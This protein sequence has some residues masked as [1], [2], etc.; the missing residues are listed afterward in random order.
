ME[1]CNELANQYV[2]ECET[3]AYSKQEQPLVKVTLCSYKNQAE[4]TEYIHSRFF[5]F[6]GG[7]GRGEKNPIYAFLSRKPRIHL[8]Y[9]F[10]CM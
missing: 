10:R 1:L 6:L 3:P 7:E 4:E 2:I 5:F 8:Y 9:W